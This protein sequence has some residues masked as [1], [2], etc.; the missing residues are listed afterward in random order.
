MN[1]GYRIQSGALADVPQIV[2][3]M[4]EYWSFEGLA[5]F[6]AARMS[7]LLARVLSHP[8]LGTVWIAR[9]GSELVGY[10]IA[11]FIFSFEFQGLVAEIDELFVLPQARRHG[12]GTALLDVAEVSLAGAGCTCVQLQLDTVNRAAH[13]FYHRRGYAARTG[14]KLFGKQLAAA[15]VG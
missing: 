3:L 5:G 14:Y 2:V 1:P 12:I 7:R 6:E 10:L 4:E 15:S 13:A 9:D 8:R 11:V